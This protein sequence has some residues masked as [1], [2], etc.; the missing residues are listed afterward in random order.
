[1]KIANILAVLLVALIL[2]SCAPAVI[3]VST[4]TTIPTSTFT[5]V[6]A[7]TVTIEATP[8]IEVSP[9]V[10][11]VP[12]EAGP[13]AGDTKVENGF[14][15]AYKEIKTPEGEYKGWF[16][17]LAVNIPLYD[18]GGM[19]SP[20]LNP[21]GKTVATNSD[22][23]VA[24]Q[25]A[26]NIGTTNV[27]IELGVANEQAIRAVTHTPHTKFFEN[28]YDVTIST[29]LTEDFVQAHGIP[30]GAAMDLFNGKLQNGKIAYNFLDGQTPY[31][32][33]VGPDSG[34]TVYVVNYDNV[35]PDPDNGF[36]EWLIPNVN[37]PRS[38]WHKFRTA[39]WGVDGH[40]IVGAIASEKPM[41]DDELRMLPIWHEATVIGNHDKD[42]HGSGLSIFLQM[43]LQYSHTKELPQLNIEK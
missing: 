27:Y 22:G 29:R 31:T 8:T 34:A 35:A 15:Y 36:W 23:S 2:A 21:D 42:V 9:T 13:K 41:S 28:M 24:W 20:T 10:T 7:A 25:A 6:P 19:Y 3:V 11:T 39:F 43:L 33:V 38:D 32:W 26:K 30:P 4:E 5:P 16:R 14:T 18:R 37:K 40:G 1:M 17:P 12:T